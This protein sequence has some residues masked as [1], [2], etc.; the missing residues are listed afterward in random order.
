METNQVKALKAAINKAIIGLARKMTQTNDELLQADLSQQIGSLMA[1]RANLSRRML[2]KNTKRLDSAI[3]SLDDLTESA[4]DAKG[5][6]DKVEAL[7]LK[8]AK[9]IDKLT[10][11]VAS[12]AKVV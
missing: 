9:T 2:K 6:V 10:R 12:L 5:D 4:K 1:Q 7:I 11:F 3:A 8:S